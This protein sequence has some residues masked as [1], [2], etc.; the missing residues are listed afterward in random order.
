MGYEDRKEELKQITDRL[1]QGI[2]D[3]YQNGKFENYLKTMSRFTNYSVNNTLLIYLQKPDASVV[4]GYRAWETKFDRHVKKGEKGIRILAPAPYKKEVET[5]KLDAGGNVVYGPDG[6]AQT[7]TVEK[8]I[9]AYKPISVFDVSQTEGKPLPEI[10][11]QMTGTVRGYD[12]FYEALRRVSPVPVEQKEFSNGANGYYSSTE[13]TIVIDSRLSQQQT[14]KTCIHEIAHSILHDRDTGTA[15]ESD[16]RTREVVAEATA[17][18]VCQHYG[19]DSSEYSF[20]YVAGWAGDR[21]V[22]QLRGSLDVI[23][24]TANDLITRIDRELKNIRL[25]QAT[26]MTYQAGDSYLVISRGTDHPGYDYCLYNRNLALQRLD[27]IS[28][29]ALRIDDAA[30]RAL[31]NNRITEPMAEVPDGKLEPM[32]GDVGAG[33][34]VEQ[35]RAFSYHR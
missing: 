19:I 18:T 2:Q 11:T 6:T 23:R 31:S 33:M 8:L 1:E 3:L 34:P 4:A 9:Q 25:E 28:N 30:A 35:S 22:P 10:A 13:K 26:E 16:Q 29:G 24:Q 32:Q 14:V 5:T 27:S 15:I 17:Y 21:D 7:E 12:N 20:G